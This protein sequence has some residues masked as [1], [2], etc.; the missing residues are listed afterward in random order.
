MGRESFSIKFY[1]NKA[2]KK[3]NQFKIYTR[4]TVNRK[5][6]E[7]ATPFAVEEQLWDADSG[8]IKRNNSTNDELVDIE[9]SIRRIRRKLLDEEKSIE[10][11]TLVEYYKGK[12]DFDSYLLKHFDK[13]IK[14]MEAK[15]ENKKN[16]VQQYKATRNIIDEFFTKKR[17]GRD[18]LLK[19]INYAFLKDFDEFLVKDYIDRRKQ[20]IQRNSIN[21]HHSRTRTVLIDAVKEELIPKNPYMS[22]ELKNTK[23]QRGYLTQ[24]E[25]VKLKEDNLG[26]NLSL[27]GV[28]D[29]FLFSV[30]TGLRF[31]DAYDLK[32]EDFKPDGKGGKI[33]SIIMGKLDDRVNVP[34]IKE[35]QEIIDKYSDDPAREVFGYVLPRYSN[36]KLNTY[37]KAIADLCGIEKKLTHHLARHT[38]ATVALNNN[39][40]IEVVQKLLGHTD[41]R[42]TQI[43]AKMMTNTIV[44][45]MQKM[46]DTF[47]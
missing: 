18:I 36:Q 41:I 21:K 44:K 28:R 19:E 7:F 30:F 24:E 46:N 9:N 25:I 2:K 5:K 4:I 35:T 17:N 43:Y 8:R 20:H 31:Q 10:A 15:S 26:G 34:V 13:F 29:F 23:T 14:R 12:K 45:E 37:L 38:F 33:I 32:I 39:I 3:G 40:P 1:L 16:T 42:T 47:N 22:F 6:A 27:Q 11:Y